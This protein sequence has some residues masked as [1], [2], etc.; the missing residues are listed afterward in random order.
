MLEYLRHR[1]TPPTDL[2]GIIAYVRG[3]WRMKLAVRGAVTVL[4]IAV[5]VF[6]AAASGLQWARFSGASVI[7]ARVL[8][9]VVLATSIFWFLVRPLR[10]RVSDEQVALY[11][12]EHEPTLQATLLSAVEAS[13]AGRDWESTALVRRLIEQAIERCLEVDAAR[14]VERLPIRRYGAALTAV[15]VAAVLTVAFGPA[16]LRS[17]LSALLLVQRDVEAF[18]PYRIQVTPGNAN[19]PKGAD[20]TISATL[21]GFDAADA[22]LMIRKNPTAAFEAMPLIRGESGAYEGLLFDVAAP[23]DYYVQANGVQSPTFQLKVVDVPYAQRIELEYHFPA[24]TGLEPQKIEDGGD[25][26]VLKGTE[27]RLRVFPTMKTPGGNVALNEKQSIPL[28]FPDADGALAASFKAETDGFYHIELVAPT[29][30][31]VSASPRYTIDI[32]QDQ[33]PTVSFARPGRDTS[34]SSIEEVFLEANAEDDFGIRDLELVYSV[35]GGPEKTVK[36]FGGTKRLAEVTAGHTLYMEEL[37]VEP[38]DAVSY[39]ARATDNSGSGQPATSDLYFLRVRP[40]KQDFKQAM[41]QGGGGGG[42]GGGQQQVDAL[43]EQQRQIIAAT[44]NVQRD[45]KT[46]TPAKLR[47]NSTVVGLSQSRLREQVEGLITRM[48]SQLVQQDPAFEKIAKLLP[49]AIEAMKEAEGQLAKTSPDQALPSEHKALTILQK[50]EEEYET[51][52]SVQRGGGGGGGGGGSQQQQELA[53]I[54]EQEL[55]KM[56][57]RYETA[58]RSQQENADRQVDELLEKLKELARRQ[59]QAAERQRR[60]LQQGGSSAGGGSTAEQQRELAAQAEEAARRLEKLAREENRQDLAESARQMREAADAMRRAAAGGD[61]QA[62]AQAQRALERL[63]DTEKRLQRGLSDRADRDSQDAKRTADEIAREQQEISAAVKNLAGAGGQRAAEAR[64]INEKKDDLGAKLGELEQQLDSASREASRQ[65]KGASRKLSE[66]AGAIRDNR[67][68]DKVQYSKALVSRGFSPDSLQA[69]END[70]AGGIEEMRDK[71]NE[72]QAALGQGDSGDKRAEAVD[73]AR[74]VARGLETLQERTR[75]RLEQGQR[76]QG[77]KD[78]QQQD[79]QG[80]QGQSGQQ[81]QTGQQGQSGQQGQGGQQAQ[82]GQQG[83]G[84]QG[85]QG[86][87]GGQGQQGQGNGQTGQAGGQQANGGFNNGLGGGGQLNNNGFGY[88]FGARAGVNGRLSPED[89]RQLQAEM[90]QWNGELQQL[91]GMLRGQDIDPR[92]LDEILKAFRQLEDDRVYKDVNELTRLQSYVTEGIKRFEF[93][94]RRQ[95]DATDD[96]VVLTGTDE[97]PEEYRKLVEQYYKSLSK[98][99][100]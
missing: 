47:E 40:F 41:S 19:V 65:E 96:S 29:G 93:N 85:Q 61:G 53:D 95:V 92:E 97:V 68:R 6:F 60:A 7:A 26:A 57:S 77:Q 39:Y 34:A 83:Q 87:Q 80:Q 46:F 98:G 56:A 64:R 30:E 13:K 74:R 78:G 35:N 32:L 88:G 11:L 67:L 86:Q 24:Y 99:T 76:G 2:L 23:I 63:Q 33:P 50:A 69:N 14:R 18:A 20:Q 49:E 70:I 42:G 27:V 17:A 45:R 89:I 51:Q 15:A 21:V 4:F 72:A 44:F 48:N 59:Q 36:L 8:L 91:R 31:K 71:L 94:L 90:R 9:G 55:D 62:S 16:F 84:G 12:E 75:E 79:Q 54:F 25:I 1:S 81:G 58:G 28:A 73:K 52:V 37:G 3:R 5:A 38:G 10:R 82:A 22:T 43:S 66:A 100:K